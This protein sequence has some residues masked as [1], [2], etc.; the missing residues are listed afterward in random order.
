MI[1]SYSKML[2]L[3]NYNLLMVPNHLLSV[4]LYNLIGRQNWKID[5][6][7]LF[8]MVCYMVFEAY[9]V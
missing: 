5:L 4:K 2:T 9:K 8:P 3:C 6:C 1:A 7:V